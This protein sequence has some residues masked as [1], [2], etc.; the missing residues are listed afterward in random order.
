MCMAESTAV[1]TG[2]GQG[3]GRAI[4][5]K[6]AANGARVV[7]VGRTE[8]KLQAVA[9]EIGDQA[10]VYSLDV[11]DS[12]L[13]AS[14]AEAMCQQFSCLDVLVNCAGEALIKSVD[15]T[16]DED[17]QRILTVNLTAPFLVSRAL[18][19]LL[20]KSANASIINLLSKVALRGYAPV[21]A[22]TAAKTGLLGLTRALAAELKADHIRV[23]ALCPGPMDTPMRWNA[24]PEMDRQLVIDPVTI[25]DTVTYLI[26]LPRGVT[27][28]EILIQSDE[29]D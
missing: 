5:H 26:S 25:A 7:L 13:V 19:P 15:Q 24:T 29:Y 11:T 21:A 14:F 17:W 8:S 22:Y 16:T 12:G 20:R 2:A 27:T 10:A 4:A 1:I 28:G 6:L 23:V 3:A 9:H 18:L